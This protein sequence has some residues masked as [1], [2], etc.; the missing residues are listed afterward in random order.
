ME[1]LNRADLLPVMMHINYAEQGQ[2]LSEACRLAKRLGYSGIEFRRKCLQGKRT[3]TEYLEEVVRAFEES[4]LESI[5]FGAPTADMVQE[6]REA[7]R[8]EV[9]ASIRFFEQAMVRL[10]L[11]IVNVTTGTFKNPD[12]SVP[13]LAYERHGSAIADD[14]TWERVVD[15]LKLLAAFAESRDLDLAAETHPHYL[16]D[17]AEACLRLCQAVD[18]PAF[19]VN[20]DYANIFYFPDRPSIDKVLGILGPYV[21]MLH[22]K[23]VGFTDD[24]HSF[25]CSMAEGVINNR[26]LLARSL[27]INPNLPICL[28]APRGGDREW[29]AA[30]DLEY[31]RS[32]LSDLE[33]TGGRVRETGVKPPHDPIL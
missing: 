33:K 24:G 29:F 28:E 21:K 9:E 14:L 15:V 23:N 16:H 26:E 13:S 12:P 19:G 6:D 10:P 30:R 2:S 32:L 27:A 11:R 3:D 8:R 25:R 5:S 22:L 1:L 7:A 20:L 17:T 18:S 4:G 31:T